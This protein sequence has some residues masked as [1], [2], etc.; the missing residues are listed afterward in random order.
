MATLEYVP[1]IPT[2]YLVVDRSGSMFHCLA[3][4]EQV[5]ANKADTA[6]SQFN[7]AMQT[8]L[9]QLETQVRFGFT[10]IFGTNPSRRRY[11]APSPP[12]A[13]SPTTS[14]RSSTTQPR[15]RRHTTV[16]PGRSSPSRQ[17][18]ARSSSRRR[19]T[20]S[21]PPPRRSWTSRTPGDKYIIFITDGQEDY[22]DDALENLRVR[23]HRRGAAGRVRREHPD[24]R[25]RPSDAAVQSARRRPGRFRERPARESRRC[26]PW[27][28][29]SIRP[30]SSISARASRP[31]API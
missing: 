16:S 11:R 19:A 9:T 8:V 13:R 18:P 6:W 25:L 27:R 29:V 15:S 3:T 12:R 24:D 28:P 26:R 20:R 5:C 10:T 23:L 22:C 1:K 2:V 21:R 30:R 14:P 17:P 31:G 4:T 7:T